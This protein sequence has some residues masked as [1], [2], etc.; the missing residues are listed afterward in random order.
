MIKNRKRGW[1]VSFAL[2]I[3]VCFRS[4]A[5]ILNFPPNAVADSVTTQEDTQVKLNV[6]A[7]DTDPNGNLDPRTVDLDVQVV[8]IQTTKSTPNGEY[9]VDT[10]GMV[11]FTPAAGYHGTATI[12]YNVRDSLDAVSNNANIKII[13]QS[14]NALP[15]AADDT[16]SGEPDKDILVSILAND[17]DSDGTL[18]TSKVDLDPAAPGIQKDK[19]TPEGDWKVDKGTLKFKSKKEYQGT[20]TITYTVSDNE[21]GV[22][23]AATVS[24]TIAIVNAAP[25]AVNDSGSTT[26]NTP[27]T[28]N[29]VVNDTDSDGTIDAAKVDLN[30]GTA[31]VQNT[32]NT[33]QGSWSV[34]PQG[35]V[36]FTPI[37]NFSGSATLSYVVSDN[38]GT[39]SNAATITINVQTVNVAPVANNDNATTTKNK[40]VTIRV[41]DNDTDSDGTIDVTKVDINTALG[42]IQTTNQT[43]QGSFSVNNLGIV[44]YTP[45]NNFT[46]IAALTY[47][48]NDNSGATSNVATINITVQNVNS[49][50]VAVNDNGATSQNTQ[51]TVNVVA[52]DTDS[53][54]VIDAAKVDL[55]TTTAGIQNTN[56]TAQG[57]YSVSN[58]GVVTYTPANNFTGTAT[59]SYTVSDNTGATSNAATITIAVQP[60]NAPV[61]NEDVATTK[62]NTAVEIN[63]VTN[64]RDSDGT[65]DIAS[66]DLNTTQT[67]IQN[68]NQTPDGNYTATNTGI[69]TYTP[70][71]DFTGKAILAYTVKDNSGV[72]S[73]AANI[74]ITVEKVNTAP[75][76]VNDNGATSQNTA[77]KLN[78][79]AND[80]DDGVVVASKVDLN[81]KTDGIQKTATTPQGAFSVDTL[82]VLTYTPAKDFTGSATLAYNVRDDDDAVSN[83]AT[84]TIAVQ[85]LNAP[86]ANEDRGTTKVNEPVDINVVAN[87]R[88][89]DGEIDAATVDLNT[90]TDGV[91]KTAT[92]AQ[93]SYSVNNQGVVR[94]TP[95]KDFVGQS[96]I[97]YTV[98]DNKGVLSN[99]ANII[100]VIEAIPDMAPEIVAFEDVTDTLRY[101]PGAPIV[102]TELFEA[103][104][105]D[106][107]DLLIVEIGFVTETYAVGSDILLF[108]DTDRIKGTFNQQAGLLT[109]SGLAPIADYIAAVRSVE[110][111]F[112]GVTE[113]KDN[114]NLKRIYVRAGDGNS[115]SEKKERVV[116]I[117]LSLT[118][119]D[120]PTA[121]TPN[122]DGANDTWEILAPGDINGSQFA[123]AELRVYD[124]RGTM[125]YGTTGLENTWDGTYQGKHLPV[126]TYYYTI[127]LKT[128][129]KRYKGAVTILR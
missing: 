75:V 15:V 110:Y 85:P 70:A 86:V 102:I 47:T 51:T 12:Q 50:P 99:Q 17:T 91:Q 116:K 5:Q 103:T 127:D 100:V 1:L 56:A 80:T 94:F 97:K 84:V 95:V 68:F 22:S 24:I 57:S 117:G 55:N 4:F 54:G 41:T 62:E 60:L 78:I 125:V 27:V 21:G 38:R 28:V 76:A 6:V 89:N 119:L 83:E 48:V 63:V 19:K 23:N 108:K 16:G 109:L 44:S 115:F 13:V 26:V 122:N 73:N 36:T 11:T 25:V 90:T 59:L 20:A 129:Q 7:N 71:K 64:D 79:V 10:T 67:G 40:V 43:T 88:D 74:T 92:T 123:N 113:S 58:L 29:V 45:A 107:E 101:T 9:S 96:T 8:G 77:V 126:D 112:T 106:D 128:Q 66:V 61:A 118:D 87:D 121:F 124:K 65:I 31:G 120:I 3:I 35:V 105:S 14:V 32:A 52:N 2:T 72:T 69:V 42:G 18:D 49:P 93:G 114:L 39:V 34:D 81:T 53:D 37:A 98:K 104:D 30:T 82:G 33:A 111:N 46:G